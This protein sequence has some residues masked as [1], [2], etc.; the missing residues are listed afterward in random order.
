MTAQ[1]PTTARLRTAPKLTRRRLQLLKLVA[2]GHSNEE[3]AV[4]L[5]V[6]PNT[7]KT[8]LAHAFRLLR[9]R[10]RQ[11][12]VAL[13]LAYGLIEPRDLRPFSLP[14]APAAG[15]RRAA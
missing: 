14:P 2:S 6:S 1:H 11:H 7:V 8:Q 13:C 12:A 3:A 10:N 9:A 15:V 4:V 5:Q